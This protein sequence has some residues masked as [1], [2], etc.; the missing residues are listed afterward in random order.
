[1][2]GPATSPTR[3]WRTT[4]GWRDTWR[5]KRRLPAR[6]PMMER[7]MT[8]APTAGADLFEI[9][10]TTRSMRRLKPDPIPDALIDQVLEAGVCAANG[11]NMQSWRFLVI[12]DPSIKAAVA[13]WYRRGWHEVTAPRYRAAGPPSG[14]SPERFARMLAAAEHLADHLHEA[15]VWIV[16]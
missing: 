8:Q 14:A 4:W 6:R 9:I 3:R 16:P 13:V 5:R 10:R 2:S 12:Q 11:G 7:H 15:P 1:M